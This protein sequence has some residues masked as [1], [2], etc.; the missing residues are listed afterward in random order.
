MAKAKSKITKVVRF[1]LG[2]SYI[3]VEGLETPHIGT[4]YTFARQPP[5]PDVEQRT[6]RVVAVDNLVDLTSMVHRAF[7]ALREI[8]E[9]AADEHGAEDA[10]N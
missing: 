4:T 9:T 1:T 10:A 2:D 7:V 5:W 3:D 6:Y 8:P